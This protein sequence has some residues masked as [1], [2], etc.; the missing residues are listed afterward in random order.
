MRITT[1]G[2]RERTL[3]TFDAYMTACETMWGVIIFLKFGELVARGGVGLALCVLAGATGVQLLNCLGL[4]AV[5]TN[6]HHNGAYNLLVANLGPTWGATTSLL[7]YLGMSA[8]ATVE[9]C[10]AVE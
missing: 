6:G 8:L 2:G 5:A 9:I 1:G 7:Y 3:S 10:G 4:S